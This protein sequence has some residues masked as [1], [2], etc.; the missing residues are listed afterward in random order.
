MTRQRKR[1]SADLRG[2]PEPLGVRTLRVGALVN[3]SSGRY[4]LGAGTEL[5]TLLKEAECRVAK[6]WYVDAGAVD[7]AL[8]DARTHEL[9]V[10]IV[11]G[12]DGTVSAAAEMCSTAGPYLIP[13]PGGTM[14]RLSKS[15]YGDLSWQD[16][17]RATLAAPIVR[18]VDGGRIGEKQFFVSAIIGNASLFAEAREAFRD[19]DI[20]KA[21]R[22]GFQAVSKTFEGSLHYDFRGQSGEAKAVYVRC[23]LTSP[24]MRDEGLAF[25]VAAITPEGALDALKLALWP[26]FSEATKDHKF[27]SANV[28]RVEI[29]SDGPILA[30]LDGETSELG[31][32]AVVDF[33]QAAFKAL[34][35]A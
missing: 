30:V 27:G 23:P 14:N 26:L 32:V 13:L 4:D 20:G 10:L 18:S 33:V 9:D 3:T 24:A 5:E 35:P 11:L 34:V 29:R 6:V 31:K 21:L 1:C 12:G 7:A 25:A 28:R 2:G 22:E 19:G 16:V 15:L 17:L 8:Q